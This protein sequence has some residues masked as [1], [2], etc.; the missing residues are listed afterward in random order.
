VLARGAL[1]AEGNSAAIRD[2]RDVQQVYL[3]T[4]RTFAARAAA[5][6]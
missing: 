1:I 6:P 4:G 3:G 2:N 5:Q